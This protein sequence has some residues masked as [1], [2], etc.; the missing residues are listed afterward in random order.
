MFRALVPGASTALCPRAP[1]ASNY[2]GAAVRF[3]LPASRRSGLCCKAASDDDAATRAPGLETISA[4]ITPVI[5]KFF[6]SDVQ[7][8]PDKPMEG[9]SQISEAIEAIGEGKYV[10]LVDGKD[11]GH[12]VMAA[13]LITPQDAHFFVKA[14]SGLMYCPMSP[15]LLDR[16]RIQ[17]M[18][19]EHGENEPTP[20]Q[21]QTV[22]VDAKLGTTTG[23]SS[24]DRANTILALASPDSRSEH[25]RKPG[26]IYPIRTHRDGV[27][28]RLGFAEAAMDLVTLAGL[29]SV[30]VTTHLAVQGLPELSK[31]AAQRG[32]PFIKVA[33]L[34]RYMKKREKLVER[35]AVARLPTKWGDFKA[36]SYKSKL[37]SIEHVAYVKGDIGDGQDVLVR[38]H[39][40]CLTGDILGSLRC[41]CRDSLAHAMQR[42]ESAGRGVLVY[43]RGHEGMRVGLAEKLSAYSMMDGGE[44]IVEE[45]AV[46]SRDYGIGAQILRDIG[47][48]TMRLMTNNPAKFLGLRG[49]GLAVTSRIPVSRGSS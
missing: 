27:L 46:D 31:F 18:V 14:G 48:R 13:S 5:D 2:P 29:P 17:L 16:L 35:T 38:V 24:Q 1:R 6:V 36:Y 37:N 47:V 45:T 22:S 20:E 8:D 49:Y 43:L 42:I 23:V 32:F 28:Y 25:F 9:F 7:G 44:S 39:S 12:L 10:V 34:G 26:H 19:R 11:T 30:A 21:A 3:P 40:E 33:D 4:Q 41:P 15:K